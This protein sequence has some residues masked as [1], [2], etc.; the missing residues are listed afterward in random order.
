LKREQKMT[1]G[2]ST[3]RKPNAQAAPESGW[4]L[5]VATVSGIPIR[6]HFSFL[7]I[8]AWI[9]WVSPPQQKLSAVLLIIAV[10]VC[11]VLHEL[12]HSI[13]AQRYG[14]GVGEIVLY[15]I[16]GIARLEKLP[17]PAQELWIALAGPAVN[18]V[19][20]GILFAVLSATGGLAPRPVETMGMANVLPNLMVLN[21]W[22]ALFNM[23]PAFPM[24]GGRVL[25]ALLALRMG[26]VRA[27]EVAAGIGQMLAIVGGFVALMAG[28]L[29]G[30]F[31][32]FFIFVGAGQ[33]AAMYRGKAL[34]EGL[35]VQAAMITDFRTLPVG[36]S[37]R[38]AA[39]VLLQ[40]SQQDF[41][42]VHGEEVVGVLPRS[43]LLRGLAESGPDAYVSEAMSREFLVV[44]PERNLEE[45][46]TDMQSG[47]NPVVLVMRDGDLL[48]IV[49]L[50][51]LA[52]LLIVRQLTQR[53]R[54]A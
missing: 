12:G 6:L 10:F 47:Q 43:S 46:A 52:E 19:I 44:P 53:G 50:E 39:E 38:Q 36:A 41:P 34:V 9:A 2:Q 42:V 30:L 48:G 54:E 51:N 25:R 3:E 22:L 1:E 27:T 35:P 16:G 32:A 24:D 40:T 15:P 17:K 14:I 11:V 7:F 21:I 18:V 37:L 29:L 8:L 33:E 28:H 13:T 49:T 23:I 45:I 4:S 31:I 20:A 26:E 5:R